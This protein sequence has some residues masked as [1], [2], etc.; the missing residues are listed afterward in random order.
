MPEQPQEAKPTF[1]WAAEFVIP[2]NPYKGQTIDQIAKTDK[3]LCFLDW[4]RDA[5]THWDK[6]PRRV[7]MAIDTYLSDPSI[8]KELF[9]ARRERALDR[10][11][12]RQQLR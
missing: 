4:A 8:E 12:E 9:N 7:I 1:R 6:P 10:E 5:W 2:F 11:Y 3:G